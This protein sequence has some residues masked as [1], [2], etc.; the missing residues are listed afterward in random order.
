MTF[1]TPFNF[2]EIVRP[3][4]ASTDLTFD[5]VAGPTID[6]LDTKEVPALIKES[7][8]PNELLSIIN[9]VQKD[10]IEPQLLSSAMDQLLSLQKSCKTDKS[11]LVRHEG[12]VKMCHLLKFKAP[13]ME[14]NELVICLKVLLYFGLNSDSVPVHRLL[15]LVRDRIN[16]FSPTNL[17][18]LN[19]VLSKAA[20]TKLTQAIRTAIPTVLDLNIDLKLDRESPKEIVDMIRYMAVPSL[21]IS[22]SSKL[23]IAKAANCLGHGFTPQQAKIMISSLSVMR[24]FEPDFE[25]VVLNCYSVMSQKMNELTFLDIETTID[26]MIEA[27]FRKLEIFY[28][29]AFFNDCVK[30]L[31]QKDVGYLNAS[32]ILRKFNK[33]NFVNL[34]LL[35]YLDE[36]LTVGGIRDGKIAGL[37]TLATGFSNAN[38]NS[39]HQET[40]RL[41]LSENLRSHLHRQEIPWLRIAQDLASIDFYAEA[42]FE[43]VF[44]TAFLEKNLNRKQKYFDHMQL[45]LLWQC[46]NLLIPGYKGPLP[47]QKFIDDALLM[48]KPMTNENFESILGELFGVAQANVVTSY[49]HLLDYVVAFDAKD[50]PVVVTAKTFEEI[51]KDLK[52]VAVFLHGA[53]D[54]PINLPRR[55][56][57][58][59]DLRLKTVR[60]LGIKTVSVFS[61]TIEALPE[62]E[63]AAFLDREVRYALK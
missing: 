16:D 54:C 7:N 29:E 15:D 19:F 24:D 36:K 23:T 11:H 6:P 32:Y 27:H 17:L 26:F 21:D 53:S 33:V 13:R 48:N 35:E 18:F 43:R 45:L 20:S 31:V 12:F 22:L 8:E 61:H 46:V 14:V 30:F 40:F 47:D 59:I 38:Y 34:H 10:S 37:I 4:A 51:P 42:L 57:G 39:K 55:L 58:A 28:N 5:R 9:G 49:G 1:H 50:A 52:T 2:V 41:L 63:R 44:S 56:R 60:A 62:C 25:N 3:T